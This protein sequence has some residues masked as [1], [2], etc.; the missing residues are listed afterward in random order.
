MTER[1]LNACE[2]RNGNLITRDTDLV[3]SLTPAVL[4][5]YQAAV[6]SLQ[7]M[8]GNLSSDQ[9]AQEQVAGESAV[10]EQ[11]FKLNRMTNEAAARTPP[12]AEAMEMLGISGANMAYGSRVSGV[13]DI[14][15]R[16][17]QITGAA[18]SLEMLASPLHM[19]VVADSVGLGKTRQALAVIDEYATAMEHCPGFST[20]GGF[21]WPLKPQ[22][23]LRRADIAQNMRGPAKPS[24]VIMPANAS[25]TWKGDVATWERAGRLKGYYWLSDQKQSGGRGDSDSRYLPASVTELKKFLDSFDENDPQTIRTVVVC[26]INCF[27]RRTTSYKEG[28]VKPKYSRHED[29]D[30]SP[31]ES[32][33]DELAAHSFSELKGY[34]G[35]VVIDEVHKFKNIATLCHNS[36]VKLEPRF[37]L[38]LTATPVWNTAVDL[39]GL[40]SFVAIT[41]EKTLGI[42]GGVPEEAKEVVSLVIGGGYFGDE[43]GPSPLPL[44]GQ[45]LTPRL[46]PRTCCC[47]C[48]ERTR[49]QLLELGTTLN[50]PRPGGRT[51]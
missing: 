9:H 15:M 17:H 16:P 10:Q 35:L 45:K 32:I 6:S 23:N 44:S 28:Y 41:R 34:A 3:N 8:S 24:L 26:S 5:Q 38:C 1:F 12:L 4:E 2:G 33:S 25:S 29:D 14:P 40:L 11:W 39:S 49:Q 46:R 22:G 7:D 18:A 21:V 36:I 31:S 20:G 30:D 51:L 50:S 37:L 27:A 42:G 48:R 43:I 13:P 47:R 19:S